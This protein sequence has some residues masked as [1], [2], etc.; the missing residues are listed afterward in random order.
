MYPIMINLEN[1]LVSVVGGGR[2]A[3]RKVKKLLEYNCYIQ[4]ISPEFTE[5]FQK[6]GEAVKLI[7]EEY[8]PERIRKSSL[9]IA[10]TSSKAIN[11]RVSEYCREHNILCNVV[12]DIELSDFIVP[13]S[14]KRGDLTISVSTM[15]KSPSLSAKIKKEIEEKYT[16]DYIDYVKCLGE[17]RELVLLKFEDE[18]VKKRILNEIVNLDYEELKKRRQQYENNSGV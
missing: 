15:G 16:D 8:A 10:A 14:I 2:V 9:V 11:Q 4:V 3:L 5:E 18:Q 12:D 13:A 6:L 17:I 7:K 1:K